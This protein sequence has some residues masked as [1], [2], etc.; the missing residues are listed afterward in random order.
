MKSV[1]SATVVFLC[2]VVVLG[3]VPVLA[4]QTPEELAKESEQACVA[5][6]SVKPTPQMIVEQRE[7]SCRA[8]GKRGQGGFPQVQ[9]KRQRVHLCRHLHL[10][11]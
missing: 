11:T 9:G 8:S 4:Q 10:D 5:S 2:M 7:Q 3:V 6:A 1:V